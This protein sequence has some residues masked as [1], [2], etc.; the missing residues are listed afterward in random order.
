MCADVSEAANANAFQ[1]WGGR[2]PI[3]VG[4]TGHRNVDA[5]DAKLIAALK[6]QC[7]LL[8]ERYEHSPFVILS[9]LA[10]AADRL[11]AQIAME[12][13]S[14]DLIAVLPMPQQE[15]ERDFAAPARWRNSGPFWV[16]PSM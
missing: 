10:E 4:A 12:E 5:K 13:L 16:A 6:A 15:Y 9:A 14:A 7:A 2:V 1:H 3:M 11:V 8:R